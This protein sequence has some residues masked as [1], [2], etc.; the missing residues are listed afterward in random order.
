MCGHQVPQCA[1]SGTFR[2]HQCGGDTAGRPGGEELLWGHRGSGWSA[3]KV[4]PSLPQ[5]G[6]CASHQVS[7][8]LTMQAKTC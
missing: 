5:P 1:D 7:G 3:S 8:L 6:L 4:G 2:L